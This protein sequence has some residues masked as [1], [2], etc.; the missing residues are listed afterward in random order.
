LSGLLAILAAVAWLGLLVGRHGFWRCDQTLDEERPLIAPDVVAIVPA[1]DEA[2][3]I[4][5]S[6]GSLLGQDYAG[7][8]DVVVVDD[9]SRDDTAARARALP[10]PAGHGL[11]V[12]AAPPPPAGWS[13]KVAAQRAGLELAAQER[14]DA[15]WLWLTDADIVHAP[16][17]LSRLVATAERREVAL[18]S[19]MAD[20]SVA[21]AVERWLVPAFVYFFQLLYPFRAVNDPRRPVAA[22]AG[23]CMLLERAALDRAGGFEA[24]RAQLIDDVALARAVKGSGAAVRLVLSHA[25]RSRRAYDLAAFWTMVRRTA[26]TELRHSWWRLAGALAGLGLLFV[27]PLVALAAAGGAGRI[28]GVLALG[29]MALSASPILR[30]YGLRAW[31]VLLW[32]PAAWAYMAMTLHSALAHACG[33]TARWRGRLYRS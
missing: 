31:R 24:V 7:R 28:A 3:L 29:A 26:F 30:W 33:R 23:G 17:A 12:R 20:L 8:L 2:A 27:V 15:R 19:V 10:V 4:E 9:G 13:G 14:L 18:V 1:R 5:A 25:C 32:P 11:H 16:D 6:V 22:A 21:S